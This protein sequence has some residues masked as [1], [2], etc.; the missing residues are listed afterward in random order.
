LSLWI[1]LIDIIFKL[2]LFSLLIYKLSEIVKGTLFPFLYNQVKKIKSAQ[3]ELMGKEKL[4][5]SSQKRIGS[6]IDEQKKMFV[7]LEKK[8]QLWHVTFVEDQNEKNQS[9]KEIIK[10]ITAKRKRQEANFSCT[11]MLKVFV[12]K[13][14]SF[15]R[16]EL[17]EKHAGKYGKDVLTE[18]ICKI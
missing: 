11:G 12:P 15:A 8:I 10:K 9:S 6:Q 14:L 7:V 5:T 3:I 13:S 16:K 4:L 18:F 1:S 17:A 2:F